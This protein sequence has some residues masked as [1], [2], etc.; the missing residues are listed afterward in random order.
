M[1]TDFST[2]YAKRS[3]DELLHLASQRHSLTTG[4]AAA[5]ALELGRRNLSESDRLEHQKFVKQQERRESHIRRR[6][7]FGKRQFSWLELLSA[8]LVMVGIAG[9]Y[10]ALPNRY[11]LNPDWGKL[12]SV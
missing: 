4:T 6:R 1:L 8:M 2:E 9:A 7:I 11:R 5:L 10:I 12:P 3:D